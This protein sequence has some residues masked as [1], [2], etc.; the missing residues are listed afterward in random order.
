MDCFGRALEIRIAQKD[1]KPIA[2]MLTIRY[3]DTLVYKYGGSDVQYKKMGGMHLLYWNSIQDAKGWGLRFFDLGRT[4]IDQVGLLTFKR[5][6]GAHESRISYSRYS[7][8]GDWAHSL[9][10]RGPS[11]ETR[12]AKFILSHTPN[13][14]LEALGNRGYGHFG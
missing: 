5:R 4:D 10:S 13:K 3:K 12:T 6:W 11:W 9:G 1:A 7:Y 14:L 8:L 2:G